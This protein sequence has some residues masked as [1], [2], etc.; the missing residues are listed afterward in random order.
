MQGMDIAVQELH[1]FYADASA[2]EMGAAPVRQCPCP[3]LVTL[4]S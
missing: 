4:Y 1:P 3:A 2:Q